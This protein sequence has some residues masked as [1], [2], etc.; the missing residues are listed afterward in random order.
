MESKELRLDE[1]IRYK[2]LNKEILPE[3]R[4]F[5]NKLNYRRE[6]RRRTSGS[7][8]KRVEPKLSDNWLLKQ[9]LNQN[10]D[11]KLYS[12]M[13]KLLNKLSD[14]NFDKLA[15]EIINLE[16]D[17]EEH[18]KTLVNFI[19]Q[20]SIS[21]SRFAP[22]YANLCRELSPHY[23]TVTDNDTNKT[24][25]IYFRE[26]LI[27]KCQQ[28]FMEGISMDKEIEDTEDKTIFKFKEHIIGCMIFIGELFNHTLLTIKI[29]HSCF[30]HLFV[31]VNLNKAYSIE[32]LCTVTRTVGTKFGKEAPK[33]L[34]EF[35][36]K[37]IELKDGNDKLSM[38]E[39]FALMDILDIS[40]RDKWLN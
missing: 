39:K 10:D 31:S 8:W 27:N 23:I 9:K 29:I 15:S 34:K 38:R 33:I 16:I 5:A 40:E 2:D 18:L 24:Q 3:L 14:S 1:F 12:Q 36:N 25:Q 7:L 19:F 28:M 35:L 26:L 17:K 4:E 6:P 21:E 30:V 20:K 11:E 37:F 32:C 22:I 13:R